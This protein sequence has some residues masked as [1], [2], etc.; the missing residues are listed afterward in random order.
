MGKRFKHPFRGRVG[1]R[2]RNP[3]GH[4]KR[5]LIAALTVGITAFLLFS[6]CEWLGDETSESVPIADALADAYDSGASR[7][8][9]HG[10]GKVRRTTHSGNAAM[11]S[12]PPPPAP[13]NASASHPAWPGGRVVE[14]AERTGDERGSTERITIVQPQNLPYPVRIAET[15]AMSKDGTEHLV[16]R[17]EVV[18]DQV[19]VRVRSGAETRLPGLADSFGVRLEKLTDRGI[20]RIHLPEAGVNRVPEAVAQLQAF[21]ELFVYAEPDAIVRPTTAPNDPHYIDGTLWG[22]HNTGQNDGLDDADIDAPEGWD[23]RSDA[24]DTIIAV[25]DSGIRYTH[26]D[27]RDNMWV[28]PGEDGLDAFGNSKRTNGI[29]DDGNGYI[30]D[31]HG[32]NAIEKNGD[33]MDKNGHGSHVAGTIGAVGNNGIGVTGVAWNA[34]IMALRFIDGGGSTSDAILCFEYAMKHGARISNNSW[35]G[36]TYNQALYDT[37]EAAYEAGM[38]VVAAAGNDNADTDSFNQYPANYQLANVLSV[39]ATDRTD[40]LAHFSNYGSGSVEIAAPGVAIHSLGIDNDSDYATES[41]TSMASPLVAGVAALVTSQFPNS[42]PVGIKN[43]LLQSARKVQALEGFVSTAAIINLHAALNTTDGRPFNDDFANATPIPADPSVLRAT[44]IHASRQLGEPAHGGSASGS[45]WYR[46]KA[47][48]SGTTLA[49]TFGSSFDTTIAVYSGSSVDNLTLL[50]AND[51]FEGASWS[52]IQWESVAGEEYFIAVAGKQGQQGYLRIT[53]SGPPVED[54]LAD[55]LTIPDFPFTYSSDNTNASR[56]P[57]EPL[58][59]DASG[60]GSLWLKLNLPDSSRQVVLNTRNS[61]FDTLL[62]VYES[63]NPD[64]DFAD[65]NL[66]VSNDDGPYQDTFS[67]VRFTALQNRTYW[68]V[69]D[70]KN[71]GRGIVRM[72]GFAQFMNDDFANALGL[73]G[74]TIDYPIPQQMIRNATREPG[75][76]NHANANGKNSLWWFWTPQTAGDFIVS[77]SSYSAIG[78]YQGSD[79]GSLVS[80]ARQREES[81]TSTRARIL[82][83]QPGSVYYIAIDTQGDAF[84]PGALQ[85]SIQPVFTVL[86]DNWQQATTLSGSPTA[87]S[88]IVQSASNLG[89]SLQGG[90]PGS[91]IAASVW[92]KW[93]P[94]ASGN[95]AVDTHFSVASAR[96]DVYEAPESRQGFA[97]FTLVGSGSQNGVDNDAWVRFTATA[98]K[99]YYFRVTSPS[100]DLAGDFNLKLRPFQRPHNDDL[101]NAEI[102]DTFFIQREIENFG[103]TREPGEPA[104]TTDNTFHNGEA[105]ARFVSVAQRTLWYKWTVSPQTARRTSASSFG[106]NL[107]T[108]VAVYEGP[109]ENATFDQLTPLAGASS[110]WHNWWAWGEFNWL[111]EVG[112]TYYIMVGFQLN[113][114]EEILRFSFWQNPNDD[115]ADRQ[116]LA[117]SNISITTANFA[118]TFE[119]GEPTHITGTYGGRSLWYEWTA[120]ASGTYIFDTIHSYLKD[121][122]FALGENP[123]MQANGGRMQM[124]IYTGSHLNNLR[125]VASNAGISMRD[126]NAMISLNATAGV[127]YYIALDSKTGP[128]ADLTGPKSEWCYRS[129][130]RF[131]ISSG[132][133]PNDAIAHATPIMGA[134]HQ[135]FIDLKFASTEVGEPSH[136]SRSSRSAW[137]KWTAPISG[138]FHLATSSD[139]FDTQDDRTPGIAI[140]RAT[141]ARPAFA[142]LIKEAEAN[143]NNYSSTYTPA[144]LA[145]DAEA[146]QTYY[147]AVDLDRNGTGSHKGFKSGLLLSQRPANDDFEDAIEITGSRRTVYGHNVGATEQ[148][149]EPDID[150]NWKKPGAANSSVWWKWTAPASGITTLTTKGSFIYAELGV[151]TGSGIGSLLEVARE[152]T[153]GAFD[154]GDSYEE[155]AALASRSLSFNAIAGQTYYF[156]VNG[157]AWDK[158]SRGPIL[159]TISGQP[160]KPLMPSALIAL[161]LSALRVQLAW[162]DEA[163]DESTYVIQ[164]APSLDGPWREVYNSGMANVTT[165]DDLEAPEAAYYRVRAEGPGGI[166]D[167]ATA[168]VDTA[169]NTSPLAMWRA[170]HF[171]AS[172]NS[173]IA[174]DDAD[175]DADGL[176]NKLEFALMSDPLRDS[177]DQAPQMHIV[178]DG[179]AWYLHFSHRRRVGTGAGTTL[180]GYT[181]DGLTYRIETANTLASSVWRSGPEALEAFSPPVDNHDGSETVSI[182]VRDPINASGPFVRL[183]IGE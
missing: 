85:L 173:P 116:V 169:D 120:P 119:P 174:A 181:V 172:A 143:N 155:R 2:G 58:H 87:I 41:G 131:N 68:I 153:A 104:H 170:R 1:R 183:I 21:S 60:G 80:V 73:S 117:G 18:A 126:F 138:T 114:R 50:A 82:N 65:L 88:P 4:M 7:T 51:D 154:N 100:P 11:K 167:W 110:H 6:L 19:L 115:F 57:G 3:E 168:F 147:I 144:Q 43:R 38:L 39:A 89:A 127:T 142:E 123:D 34:R 31:V 111:P 108:V 113:S 161:R 107:G 9:P 63:S 165:W 105:N 175:P 159:L 90:E 14:V 141:T 103:S 67:E 109:A 179:D 26:E 156:L 83:A 139:I 133:L 37:L 17:V 91:G 178:P 48:N 16:E 74:D 171:G 76:P 36:P 157:S 47:D 56:E 94:V 13:P 135:E 45:I 146:G 55:A 148:A 106:S 162:H 53:F 27:I 25:I 149:G 177:R 30:D 35:G 125:R 52:R 54:N 64:P 23:I 164:R 66:V 98:G 176:P 10:T 59:A 124:A 101:A 92:Y 79:L 150:P 24:S 84:I 129:V 46:W 182:R 96:L 118:A 128:S 158:Q 134:Y 166:G 93:V 22:M 77:A 81:N 132:S 32:F 42:D 70:G 33:P 180:T 72:R 44:N 78:I 8:Q 86:N 152:T 69:T 28:N 29:D 163:V 145:F 12:A 71:N 97:D 5:A 140:Y 136:G 49:S 112:K 95:F 15:F 40:A 160:G 130:I 122:F 61:T 137:W 102:I 62:A 151:Y 121:R 99:V 75:E 20:Y